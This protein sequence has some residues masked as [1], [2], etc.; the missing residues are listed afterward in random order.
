M[1]IVCKAIAGLTLWCYIQAQDSTD[2]EVINMK[3]STNIKPISY[4]ASHIAEVVRNL[5][6]DRTPLIITQNGE[7]KMII[8]DVRSYEQ[9]EEQLALLKILVMGKKDAQAGKGMV[10]D[11]FRKQLAEFQPLEEVM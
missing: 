1:Q 8:E 5:E 3:Y 9:K 7:A 2:S 10:V 4:L 11:E 6:N